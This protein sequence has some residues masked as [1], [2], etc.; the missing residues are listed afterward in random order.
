MI[1][2]YLMLDGNTFSEKLRL[3]EED[4]NVVSDEMQYLEADVN[5]LK[6]I[7]AGE[8]S[9]CW[10][11]DLLQLLGEINEDYL[12]LLALTRGVLD[13]GNIIA[14]AARKVAKEFGR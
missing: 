6:K 8:A 4:M 10:C 14:D 2:N 3:I 1:M 5:E 11:T 9:S 7:W 13:K 12:K